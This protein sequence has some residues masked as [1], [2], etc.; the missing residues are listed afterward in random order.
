MCEQG[1][2]TGSL[3]VLGDD[4]L[5]TLHGRGVLGRIAMSRPSDL[6]SLPF[7]VCAAR[8]ASVDSTGEAAK[9]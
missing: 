3:V 6:D 2:L 4:W 8:A 5:S 9:G 7:Q 1:R